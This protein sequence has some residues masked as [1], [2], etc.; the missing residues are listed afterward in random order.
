MGMYDEIICDYPILGGLPTWIKKHAFQ[1]KDLD[2]RLEQF[3]INADGTFSDSSFTGMLNFYS[4]NVVG[5]GPGIYTSQGEDA[6]YIDCTA[7]IVDG[8]LVGEIKVDRNS[9][10]AWHIDRMGISHKPSKEDIK[11]WQQRQ[12]EKLIGRR[13]YVLW[14][15]Q[16]VGYW[17][18]V[19]AEN[20]KQLCVV[21]E[22]DSGYH[23]K[24][25]FELI[26]RFQRDNTFFDSDTLALER[27]KN[28]TDEWNR[29]REEFEKFKVG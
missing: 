11:K 10:K 25:D 5:S 21:H 29:Q 9:H 4:S 22:A 23:K 17:V 7:K 14:G 18:K 24:N 15:G 26:G 13:L 8:K 12:S 1:T 6:E 28:K 16:E 27:R 2:C 3:R 19:I 20:D